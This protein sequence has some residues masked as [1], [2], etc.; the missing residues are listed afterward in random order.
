MDITEF[1]DDV[2]LQKLDE[3]DF[4]QMCKSLK[5]FWN[6]CMNNKELHKKYRKISHTQNKNIFLHPIQGV[7]N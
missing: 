2:K 7:K 3:N 6:V 4:L 1:P 5:G